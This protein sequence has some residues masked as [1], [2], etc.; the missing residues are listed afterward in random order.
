MILLQRHLLRATAGPFAFG[1]FVIT[2]VLIID[3][4]YRYV[5]LF[6]TKGV[7]FLVATEVLLLSLG[8][9]FALSVPMAVL[10]G[11][12]M[13]VG[14][15]ATDHE[16]TAMKA[17]G[18]GLYAILR[19]LLFG[20]ALV[21]AGLT[22]YNHYVFPESNHRLANLLTDIKHKRP[23]M[24]IREQLFTDLNDR[25]TI[26]V[27]EKDEK[28]NEIFDVVILERSGP[29]DVS[30]T[31]TTAA[32]GRIVPLHDSNAMRIELFDGEIHDLP[33]D[34]DLSKYTITR[35]RQHDLHLRDVEQDLEDTGRTN[36]G[37]REMNFTAL[38]GAAAE[39]RRD[40]RETLAGQRALAAGAAARQW[41]LLDA[42]GRG[43]LAEAPSGDAVQTRGR[44]LE[45]LRATRQEVQRVRRAS[46][47]QQSV[48][49]SKQAR[50]NAYLVEFHKKLAIP[51]AC[52]VFVLIGL[53]MA[54]T[55]S[56]SGR[57][58]SLTLALA[59]YLV[60][61]L[62]LVGG[63][64]MADRGR[65]DPAVAMWAA[66]AVLAAVGIPLLVHAAHEGSWFRRT[67]RP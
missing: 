58:V 38:L 62:F 30:P 23:M 44:R 52:L 39:A 66:D 18:V 37:D 6:V 21:A 2:F 41:Q 43:G 17:S 63:E 4:L 36:R 64:K 34:R 9:T 11:V 42:P 67:R 49:R 50:E 22:A 27:K 47:F 57:G 8:Y 33:D 56:R 40:R 3:N 26:F 54:V 24:E 31:M 15:L 25:T 10:V 13:G 61:Y 14:Q 48:L 32:R 60:Y 7:S 28:T 65:L 55:A 19:P 46:E 1:F 45:L 5:D 20:A 59:F 35:F 12:L 51:V 53:P 16:I 29:G